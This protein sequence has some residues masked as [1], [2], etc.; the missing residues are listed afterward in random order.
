MREDLG[1]DSSEQ[2]SKIERELFLRVFSPSP[3]PPSLSSR[4]A[5]ILEDVY[6][7]K[8]Q[9]LF[10]RGDE[11]RF[12]VFIVSGELS[13]FAEETDEPILF[14]PGAI[15]GMLDLNIGRR[16][17][18]TAR[19]TVDCH[20]LRVD[21][22][23]W[24]ELTEDHPEYTALTRKRV[25]Q[26]VHDLLL[27]M[28]AP[29]ASG[30]KA[31]PFTLFEKS[32]LAPFRDG[33]MVYRIAALRAV[34]VFEKAKVESL[35]ELAKRAKLLRTEPG[36]LIAPPGSRSDRLFVVMRGEVEAER[37]VMPEL[38]AS[39]GPGQLVLGSAALSGALRSYAITSTAQSLVL[40]LEHHDLDDV[41]DDQFDIVL[42]GLRGMSIER[43]ALMSLRTKRATVPPPGA[44]LPPAEDLLPRLT[45]EGVGPTS[46]RPTTVR[47]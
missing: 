42:S 44:G 30:S 1:Q 22:A 45:S 7:K 18:R 37:R 36:E 46:S 31:A 16:R 21:Y 33:S 19:A 6:L 12:A 26:G 15:V 38:R 39:F 43:D 9:T 25:A 14:G 20:V 24:V 32:T 40:A 8:G 35:V 29:G 5:S 28:A 11:S 4:M 17:A 3:P 27:A 10:T 2:A 34:L 47:P 13:M 23:K 41:A